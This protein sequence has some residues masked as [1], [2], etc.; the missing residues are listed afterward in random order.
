M[1]F[2]YNS[3]YDT[4]KKVLIDSEGRQREIMLENLI[5]KYR[6]EIYKWNLRKIINSAKKNKTLTILLLAYVILILGSIILSFILSNPYILIFTYI[7]IVLFAILLQ[8]YTP[9]DCE[10]FITKKQQHLY[11]TIAFLETAL[12]EKS[13][14][15]AEQVDLL[16]ERVTLFIESKTPFKKVFSRILQFAKFIILPVIGFIVGILSDRMKQIDFKS[17]VI[18]ALAIVVLLA[19]I[20]FI[21]CEL[22][23]VLQIFFCGDYNAAIAFREDLKDIKLL[24]FSNPQIALKRLE[25]I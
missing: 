4:D 19:F 12:P 20:Y 18:L 10:Q 5:I 21:W 13:L 1:G 2:C 17:V 15:S 6:V 11:K 14:F 8:Q 9:K 16:I 24:Y 25:K 22:V 7:I 3:N 23:T